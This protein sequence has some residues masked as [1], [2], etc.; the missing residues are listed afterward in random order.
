MQCP[1]AIVLGAMGLLTSFS[2]VFAA[3]AEEQAKAT[4]H[5]IKGGGHGFGGA[6][7]DTPKSLF[8]MAARFF[9]KHLK[10]AETEDETGVRS[11]PVIG[12]PRRD[13]TSFARAYRWAGGRA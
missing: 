6:T 9:D 10:G 2:I 12:R 3:S 13:A 4:L 7:E 1:K 5:R 8:E 11:A